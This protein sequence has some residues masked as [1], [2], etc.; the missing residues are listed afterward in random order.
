MESHTG[1]LKSYRSFNSKY[2]PLGKQKYDNLPFLEELLIMI[3]DRDF[4]KG[5]G[6][7]IKR[8]LMEVST[9]LK[10]TPFTK[11]ERVLKLFSSESELNKYMKKSDK[12]LK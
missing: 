7:V 3:G 11:K 5:E 12:I 4:I 9:I 1:K 2:S 8:L 6:I 10:I